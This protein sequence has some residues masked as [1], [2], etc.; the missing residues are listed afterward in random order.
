[1]PG[2]AVHEVDESHGGGLIEVT[3]GDALDVRLAENAT[4]GFRWRIEGAG[5]PVVELEDD[6]TS[7][8]STGR[9]GEGGS[10]RL[11]FRAAAAG[12]AKLELA[13]A[14]R[15]PADAQPA[16]K[17]VLRVRVRP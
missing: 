15:V 13:Y 5:A 1:M 9:P 14:R 16:K 4:T 17:F 11:R 6:R 10:R 2:G 3:R 12:S 7:P 8:G